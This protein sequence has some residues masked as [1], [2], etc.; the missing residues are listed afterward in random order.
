[1]RATAKLLVATH[2]DCG[3][4]ETTIG[5]PERP[6]R[7]AAAIAGAALPGAAQ[8][9]VPVD[10]ERA[11]AALR[12]VHTPGLIGR[13]EKACSSAPALFECDDNPISP[14]SFRA[15]LAATHCGLAAVAAALGGEAIRVW[16]PVRPPGHHALRDR[17]MGFC[18]FNNA[19]V[20]AEELLQR[21]AGPVAIVDFDVHHGNGTQAHFWERDDAFFLSLHRYPFYPGTGS[22]DEVGGGPGWGFTRNFPL[23]AG[24]GDEIWASALAAG[25]DEI[26]AAYSP[27]AWVVSAGFDAHR[28]DPLGGM[29][30]S[31]AGYATFGR[32]IHEASG[33]NPV[34]AVLEGGYNLEA[35]R[36]SVRAFLTGLTGV[37]A[38]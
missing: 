13:F 17:P 33:R 8:I 25:L 29:E 12:R 4:H 2:V 31:E 16:V 1:M 19:A 24:A 11:H 28:R 21:G 23:V 37:V 20:L 36:E 15:A 6:T 18:F 9:R 5:H 30:V 10:E 3:L 32:L 7:L 14:G 27:M 26:L 35:L 38:P 22:G 34:I